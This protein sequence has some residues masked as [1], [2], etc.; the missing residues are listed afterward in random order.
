MNKKGK[1]YFIFGSYH[2]DNEIIVKISISFDFVKGEF[3][4]IEYINGKKFPFIVYNLNFTS[5]KISFYKKNISNSNKT[6][7]ET[8]CFKASGIY[9][10]FSKTKDKKNKFIVYL[11]PIET[12]SNLWVF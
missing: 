12:K 1:F 4:G 3:F 2:F 7:I 9:Q 8:K 11:D 6:K 5:E 10:G